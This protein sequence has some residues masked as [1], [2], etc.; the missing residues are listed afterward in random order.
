MSVIKSSAKFRILVCGRRWGKTVVEEIL[1]AET[2]LRKR[3]PVGWFAPNYKY[4]GE[5]YRELKRRLAPIT[6]ASNHERFIEILGTHRIDFWTMEDL[7]AGRGFKYG[8]AIVDEAG[9]VKDLKTVLEEAILPTLTDFDG[10]LVVAGTPKGRNHLYQLFRNGADGIPEY[11]SFQKPTSSNPTLKP[12]AYDKQRLLDS[13]YSERAYAQEYEAEFLDDAGGVF[14]GVD[15]VVEKGHSKNV[16]TSNRN[17]CGI[18]LAQVEDYTVVCILDSNGRQIYFDRFRRLPWKQTIERIL[19][20]IE[21][22]NPLVVLDASGV[23]SPI[24][25]W[26]KMQTKLKVVP[27][28]FSHQSKVELI[29]RA[30]KAI[31]EGSVSLMDLDIQTDELKAYEYEV[32]KGGRVTMNAPPGFHDDCV[33]AFALA[34]YARALPRVGVGVA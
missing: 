33:I 3:Q 34:Q 18:D 24:W 12:R 19:K 4:L 23:G 29:E 31:E 20:G 22:Y 5:P 26:L 1:A 16:L 17:S 7:D 9:M 27:F 30:V 32:T 2:L 8:R 28:K 15:Q 11:E 14:V 25:E 10:D 21:P 6:S 13:G